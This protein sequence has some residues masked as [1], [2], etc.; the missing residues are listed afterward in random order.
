MQ[1]TV[2]LSLSLQIIEGEWWKSVVMILFHAVAFCV[3][4]LTLCYPLAKYPEVW[5]DPRKE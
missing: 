4:L 5:P 3:V 2:I 1:N